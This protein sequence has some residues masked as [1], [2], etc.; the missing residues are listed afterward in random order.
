MFLGDGFDELLDSGGNRK[1]LS[2]D[3]LRILGQEQ[4][5]IVATDL[6][7]LRD[8]LLVAFQFS[9]SLPQ[10]LHERPGRIA[11]RKEWP[12]DRIRPSPSDVR[13]PC[14]ACGTAV[15]EKFFERGDILKFWSSLKGT[16]RGEFALLRKGAEPASDE[17]AQVYEVRRRVKIGLTALKS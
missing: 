8:E 16:C 4:I 7:Q 1:H 12:P 5:G 13:R 11:R 3:R 14:V 15:A 10:G 9:K 6:F 17:L 2:Q